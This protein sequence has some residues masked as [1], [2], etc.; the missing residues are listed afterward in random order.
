MDDNAREMWNHLE[1]FFERA[2][3]SMVT[4]ESQSAPTISTSSTSNPDPQ[5]ITSITS[6][7]TRAPRS[8]EI[9]SE[10]SRIGA[11]NDVR[12]EVAFLF[13]PQRNVPANRSEQA[14]NVPT[15]QT[16]TSQNSFNPVAASEGRRSR[17]ARRSLSR[18]S[19]FTRTF[20]LLPS[21]LCN[22][23]PRGAYRDH[24]TQQNLIADVTFRS[25]Q[26]ASAIRQQI[27]MTFQR[28]GHLQNSRQGIIS[29]NIITLVLLSF[30][31]NTVIIIEYFHIII[32]Y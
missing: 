23:I 12:R 14:L 19:R 16:N 22:F 9:L 24:L 3:R 17:S 6:S 28:N 7:V 30:L 8:N 31:S 2:R 10:L 29:Y 1:G 26:N 27:I 20:V 21:P 5:N 13:S 25:G 15:T 4:T 11:R 18:G 32:C